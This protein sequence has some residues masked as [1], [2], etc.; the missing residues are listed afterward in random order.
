MTCTLEK[1]QQP[2]P[3]EIQSA[4][5]MMRSNLNGV[6]RNK[7][8][9]SGPYFLTGGRRSVMEDEGLGMKAAGEAGLG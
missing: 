8:N 3:V 1:Q 9:K 6:G 7:V 5:L 2:P 4:A